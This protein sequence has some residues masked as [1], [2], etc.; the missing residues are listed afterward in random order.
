MTSKNT[1]Y[2]CVKDRNLAKRNKS[3][4]KRSN[5]QEA[6]RSKTSIRRYKESRIPAKRSKP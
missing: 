5:K 4:A 2:P 3:Q 1:K 6:K